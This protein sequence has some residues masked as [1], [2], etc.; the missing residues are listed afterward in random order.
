MVI[1]YLLINLNNFKKFNRELMIFSKLFVKEIKNI[2]KLNI[3]SLK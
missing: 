2:L 3:F 1:N